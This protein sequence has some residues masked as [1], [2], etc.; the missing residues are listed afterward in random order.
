MDKA[1]KVYLA[2]S[3]DVEE[4]GLFCGSYRRVNP[5]VTNISAM[6]RLAPLLERGIKPTFF[7][8]WSVLADPASRKAID[9][10]RGKYKLEIGAHL[11]HWNTPPLQEFPGMPE[12]VS[13]VPAASVPL[14]NMAAKLE[15]LFS[16]ARDFN[17]SPVKSF[18]MGRWD[19]HRE[20]WPLLLHNGVQCDASVR[21]L[22]MSRHKNSSPDHFDACHDPYLVRW[23]DG[24][25]LEIPLTVTPLHPLLAKFGGKGEI[26]KIHRSMLRKWGC[27]TLLPVEH[28]LWLMKLTTLLHVRRGGRVLSLTW[29]SSEMMPGGAP[30]MRDENSVSLFMNKMEA[31]AGWLE[32][33]FDIQYETMSGIKSRLGGSV[34]VVEKGDGDWR[35]SSC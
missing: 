6:G 13:Q 3:L 9:A 5:Q 19:L 26:G 10:L 14:D 7:C 31:Y 25:I 8:A 20:V 4:E 27:L 34:P 23:T 12:K 17:G 29:H 16:L 30:H 1:E 22:H 18:R 2:L 33:T 24:Q 35:F 11:H 32:K 28:P 15:N 21:P